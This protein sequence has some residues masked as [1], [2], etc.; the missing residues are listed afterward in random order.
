MV[1]WNPFRDRAGGLR[2]SIALVWGGVRPLGQVLDARL[3]RCLVLGLDGR[4]DLVSIDRDLGRRLDA[5]PH[6]RADDFEDRD[7]H[8]VAETD[9]LTGLP[10][11]YEHVG[12]PP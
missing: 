12:T 8:V 11:D 2:A 4:P 3:R 6:R 10:R 5:E 9:P 1:L 7:G